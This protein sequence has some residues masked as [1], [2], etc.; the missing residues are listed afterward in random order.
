MASILLTSPGR[1]G[2]HWL[3]WMLRDATGLRKYPLVPQGTDRDARWE[4]LVR[5]AVE[6]A[7][8]GYFFIQHPPFHYLREIPITT[9]IIALVRDPRDIAISM[10]YYALRDDADLDKIEISWQA[11]G[12]P[13]DGSEEEMLSY[14]KEQGFNLPW[15][16]SY[17]ANVPGYRIPHILVRYEDLMQDTEGELARILQCLGRSLPQEEIRNIVQGR[18]FGSFAEGRERGIE[19]K[20]HHYR[21]G[22]VGDWANYFTEEENTRFCAKYRWYMEH[23][24]YKEKSN[25]DTM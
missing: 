21:K 23:F 4:G 18:S 25:G 15:W 22:V 20:S 12:L 3:G 13:R 6:H 19:D 1:C 7:K 9:Q 24:R 10:A 5:E 11:V 16:I 17:M 2:S 14:C 8:E